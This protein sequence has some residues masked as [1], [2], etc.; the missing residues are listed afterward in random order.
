MAQIFF[1]AN[2]ERALELIDSLR[3]QVRKR[4][5]FETDLASALKRLSQEDP[6]FIFIQGSLD[7]ASCEDIAMRARALVTN[8]ALQLVLLSDDE[9]PPESLA[10]T[11]DW[12]VSID[13][14]PAQLTDQVLH[15]LRS[16]A[17]ARPQAI[18]PQLQGFFNP[19]DAS[20]LKI[21]I[22][23][24]NDFEPHPVPLWQP[25]RHESS[26]VFLGDDLDDEEEAESY[27]EAEL[28]EM[29]EPPEGIGFFVPERNDTP[30]PAQVEMSGTEPAEPEAAVPAPQNA[31]QDGPATVA[32]KPPVS[33]YPTPAQIYRKA[34]EL[35]GLDVAGGEA[36]G[37][38]G[39]KE[40]LWGKNRFGWCIAIFG[41]V[42]LSLG[43]LA[44]QWHSP[45][46]PKKPATQAPPGPGAVATAPP[47]QA[48]GAA[49]PRF[50]P[51]VPADAAYATAHPGWERYRD[52][53]LQF[54]IFRENGKLKAV[55]VLGE[56]NGEIPESLVRSS[57]KELSGSDLPASGSSR[58]HNGIR[59]ETRSAKSGVEA[60]IYRSTENGR[61]VGFVLQLPVK[62]RK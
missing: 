53:R 59:M 28:A 10:Y 34:P 51:K 37:T 30:P 19:E 56:G 32:K 25:D 13:L 43:A 26:L 42:L 40:A 33:L 60:A 52:G 21:P 23:D 36:A 58:E 41:A 29:D 15:L 55:Q 3:P 2:D 12:S 49:L 16:D 4:I 27:A 44:L 5:T 38:T 54:R 46:E 6:E 24:K 57:F 1:I 11:F 22:I 61:I 8:E 9:S 31:G 7:G 39:R 50:I 18:N 35:C 47:A 14:P 45:S 20:E 48:Q 17:P 62:E